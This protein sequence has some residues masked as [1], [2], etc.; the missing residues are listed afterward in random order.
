M[1]LLA[2]V[3]SVSRWIL[4]SSFIIEKYQ[5][6]PAT[7]ENFRADI[8]SDEG[9]SVAYLAFLPCF[10]ILISIQICLKEIGAHKIMIRMIVRKFNLLSE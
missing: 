3:I 4:T 2:V 6:K 9:D 10:L 1:L 7:K 8:I 5:A